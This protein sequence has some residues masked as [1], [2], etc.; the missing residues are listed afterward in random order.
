MK[1]NGTIKKIFIQAG[2]NCETETG[3]APV[4]K[5]SYLC[6]TFNEMFEQKIKERDEMRKKRAFLLQGWKNEIPSDMHR[7]LLVDESPPPM[8]SSLVMPKP[9]STKSAS[10]RPKNFTPPNEVNKP[11][12]VE[13]LLASINTQS[14][15]D[16]GNLKRFIDIS[17]PIMVQ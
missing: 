12:T 8:K 15:N 11:R 5:K 14:E 4:Q 10:F 7:K 6:Q 13:S 9:L 16:E 3:Q 1:S 17:T 2:F